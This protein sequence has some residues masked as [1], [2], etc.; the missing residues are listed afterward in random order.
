MADSAE[1]RTPGAGA[2]KT[3]N[4]CAVAIVGAG[5][6]GSMLAVHLTK[7]L[8]SGAKIALADQSGLYGPGLAFGRCA[9]E[10][11]L[12]VRAGKMSALPDRP[13]DFVR[14][15][16]TADA[17]VFAPRRV[18]GNYVG[19]LLEAKAE[20]GGAIEMIAAEVVD[21]RGE[22][23][24]F[25][26]QTLD[27]RYVH[28]GSVVLATGNFSPRRLL[29]HARNCGRVIEDPWDF[30]RLSSL[31]MDAQVLIVGT[32]LSGLDCLV[33]LAKRSFRGNIHMVSSRALFPQPHA[34]DADAAMPP[35]SVLRAR[36]ALTLL[37]SMRAAA[38]DA[39]KPAAD[40]RCVV[41]GLR[42]YTQQ[43]WQCL[44]D[45][46]RRRFLRHVRPYWEIHRHRIAP[47]ILAVRDAMLQTGQ[48][49]VRAARI[50]ELEQRPNALTV[51]IR[52]RGRRDHDV[53]EVGWVI[54]CTGPESDYERIG[55]LLIAN[56]LRRG[57]IRKDPLSLGLAATAAGEILGAD[58]APA[59]GFFTI[60]PPLR[61]V[62]Y[63]TTAVAEI[64]MQA[65]T[66]A[67]RIGATVRT[68]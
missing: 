26:V 59:Q 51:R 48:L 31:P 1:L 19:R 21:V 3:P 41:D 62:L 57:R 5:F 11:L 68:R 16:A 64:R 39:A 53:L 55:S 23:G 2:E 54:N 22:A 25:V 67:E 66:L 35:L 10:H 8:P 37:R 52:G 9:D 30:D 24:N 14:A 15:L 65:Q 36:T 33:S 44:D 27:G 58:H 38:A 63:E 29:E 56:L 49:S 61:G 20:Q 13:D 45:R 60:G 4:R 18:F 6:S 42:P 40:W 17:D 46:E 28:A 43:L 47:Q 12:N 34:Q 50:V 7:V 32:G